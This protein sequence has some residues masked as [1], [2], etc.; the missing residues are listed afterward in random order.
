MGAS[1]RVLLPA[2][3]E[4]LSTVSGVF[5]QCSQLLTEDLWVKVLR[6]HVISPESE[7]L[8]SSGEV[9]GFLIDE[10]GDDAIRV[11]IPPLCLR[12]R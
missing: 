7:S 12:R 4:A 9:V 6:S 11:A 8:L 3:K 2:L 1:N 5:S 10:E